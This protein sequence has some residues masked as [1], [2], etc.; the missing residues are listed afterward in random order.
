MKTSRRALAEP[1]ALERYLRSRILPRFVVRLREIEDQVAEHR[2]R[3]GRRYTEVKALSANDRRR[4]EE[5]WRAIAQTW[6]FGSINELIGQH[7]AYYPIERNL[8]VDPHTGD[9]VPVAGRT[10][11]REPLGPEWILER[12]PP[13]PDDASDQPGP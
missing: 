5:R 8:P 12:F 2:R 11:R 7:N 6:D 13:T 10:Y 4:F 9:Y 1:R 3:L